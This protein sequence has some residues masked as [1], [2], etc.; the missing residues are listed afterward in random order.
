MPFHVGLDLGQSA[1]Y[2]ALAVVQTV[3]KEYPNGGTQKS[4]H[5]RHLERYQLRTPYP[6]IADKVATLMR[7]PELSPTEYAPETLRY[8]SRAPDLAVD[9]TGV[10]V[11]V[12]DLL[13]ARGLRFAAVTITGG[14]RAHRAKGTWR[15]PKQDLVAALEVPFHMGELKVAEGL[16]LWEVLRGELLNFRRKID[17]RTAHDSYE[18]WR[19]A[20]HDDLVLAT[21][22]ACWSAWQRRD[23]L[24]VYSKPPGF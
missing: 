4:L 14:D 9:H 3:A 24:R 5:L 10:G 12:T 21:A 15:V 18:H 13:K 2:T 11:A 1:D 17:L 8:F 23:V 19:E 16:E 6:E 7:S 20:D 22:L